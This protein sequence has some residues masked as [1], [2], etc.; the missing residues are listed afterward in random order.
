M[1]QFISKVS[2]AAIAVVLAM[3]MAFANPPKP[4]ELVLLQA[5]TASTLAGPVSLQSK[6][7]G[8]RYWGVVEHRPESSK[9]VLP[10]L[11]E[12]ASGTSGTWAIAI[13]KKVC[14]GMESPAKLEVLLK[15]VVTSPDY[16]AGDKV[17]ATPAK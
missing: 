13:S 12:Q 14:A 7:T 16:Q 5:I 8:C 3:P 15:N 2:M 1:S 17:L 4:F 10:K 9:G 11:V 6:E